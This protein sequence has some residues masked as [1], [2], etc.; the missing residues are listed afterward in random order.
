VNN[1]PYLAIDPDV[2]ESLPPELLKQFYNPLPLITG[3][4]NRPS[5]NKTLLDRSRIDHQYT[6][7]LLNAKVIAE[8]SG[9][10]LKNHIFR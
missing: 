7:H 5:Y 10:T 4:E 8:A 2:Q 1:L 3:V 6:Y 9:T